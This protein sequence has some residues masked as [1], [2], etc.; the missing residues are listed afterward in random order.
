MSIRTLNP[1]RSTSS[2][3]KQEIETSALI[4]DFKK[5]DRLVI[6]YDGKK[7]DPL[8]FIGTVSKRSVADKTLFIRFDDGEVAEFPATRKWVLGKC[9]SNKVRKTALPVKDL[10]KWISP[11]DVAGFLGRARPKVDTTVKVAKEKPVAQIPTQTQADKKNPLLPTIKQ[12]ETKDVV[13]TVKIDKVQK[14][15]LKMKPA[16]AL[17]EYEKTYRNMYNKQM[18]KFYIQKYVKGETTFKLDKQIS[19]LEDYARQLERAAGDLTACSKIRRHIIVMED[20]ER[21]EK[22]KKE[23]QVQIEQF[24]PEYF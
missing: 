24:K 19:E 15:P 12:V 23:F 6:N 7:Q 21:Q 11:D 9:T 1:A 17:A 18:R 20:Q 8:I 14:G 5:G 4:D 3:D 2:H 13:H 16:E 22:L 10:P